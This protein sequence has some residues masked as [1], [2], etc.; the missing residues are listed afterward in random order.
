M[1]N[2]LTGCAV[3]LGSRISKT[4]KDQFVFVVSTKSSAAASLPVLRIVVYEAKHPICTDPFGD[5]GQ[6]V[7]R[8]DDIPVKSNMDMKDQVVLDAG[9]SSKLAVGET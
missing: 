5:S 3:V 1:E 4:A 6:W 7:M 8:S 2:G 9:L